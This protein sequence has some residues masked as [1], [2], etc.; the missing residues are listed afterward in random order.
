V[1]HHIVVKLRNVLPGDLGIPDWHH[2]IGDKSVV[3]EQVEPGIDRV[4]RGHR[5]E[6][7]L[8]RE[9]APAGVT[10]NDDEI[11][12]GLDRT[13]RLILQ[14]DAPLPP[15]LV[16]EIRAL[17][18]V[19][20]AHGIDVAETPLPE[21][22]TETSITGPSPGDLIYLSYA[23]ALT[24]GHPEVRVAVLDTGAD[25]GHPELQGKI[26]EH[27]N[28][29]DLQGLDTRDFIGHFR[30]ADDDVTDE[31]GHGT[32]VSGI[33]GARGLQMDEG[34]APDCSLVAVRVL[35]TMVRDGRRYGAGIVDNINRGIKHAVDAARA[36]VINMSLGIKHEGGALPHA[37][38]IRYALSRNVTVVA[39][40][41]NDGS[42]E[43]YY[44]GALPGVCAVGA[45]TAE[46]AVTTFTS[47]GAPI[48][49]VAPGTNVYSS[50]ANH[51][52]A[53]ASG[54]SQASPFVAGSV[55]LMKSYARDQGAQLTNPM[56]ADLL[57]RTS[58]K[59]DNQLRNER[60]G[61]GLVNLADGF[62]FLVH[63]MN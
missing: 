60:A 26:V 1:N 58:D 15:G 17:L 21:V 16:Q 20:S 53:V 38:I 25:L 4:M 11:R 40:S 37:D 28:F 41:G 18:P 63:S 56:I 51:G 48:T 46:G 22:A 3:H 55:A 6:F 36:D 39:A 27:A 14:G 57:E 54:T 44:P 13:Y 62:K 23:K 35:A 2:F 9:Y 19:E 8:T 7:W 24:R 32:H 50:F 33:I 30:G 45:V 52:Y 42:P 12:H 47:Y 31:V 5:L 59:V 43:R 61:Y 34:V 49:C 29:V 10:W